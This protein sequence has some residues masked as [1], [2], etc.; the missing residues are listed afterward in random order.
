MTI[1]TLK[2][3]TVIHTCKGEKTNLNQ[4][5]SEK[6]CNKKLSKINELKFFLKKR[7]PHKKE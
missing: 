4:Q 7:L 1:K 2:W 6:I 5:K 3:L